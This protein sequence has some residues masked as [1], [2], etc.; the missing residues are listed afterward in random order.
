[1]ICL[2]ARPVGRPALPGRA[3]RAPAGAPGG[4]RRPVREGP[5]AACGTAVRRPDRPAETKVDRPPRAGRHA[6][7]R[8]GDETHTAPAGVPRRL[9]AAQPADSVG[10]GARH[11]SSAL[12]FT[13]VV[14]LPPALIGLG[15]T[16]AWAVGSVAGI[17]LGALADR[18]GPRGASVL[19]AA[20][21]AACAAS[22]RCVRSSAGSASPS[23]PP[24]GPAT[25]RGSSGPGCP[26]PGPRAP[27][28]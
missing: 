17:P 24:T 26:S 2:A 7:A 27:W 28:S 13:R 19:P 16:L 10:D 12:F 4:S 8:G 15:P 22:F 21:T 11:A 3:R 18:R 23:R 5:A 20:A 6:A 9:A 1:M 25:T 14:G